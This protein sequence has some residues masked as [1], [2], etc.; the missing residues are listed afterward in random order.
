M[1]VGLGI[2]LA[3]VE[4]IEGA[5]RRFGE[6]FLRRIY[7]E[8]EISYCQSRGNSFERFAGRFAAKEAAMKAIGTG[9]RR[10][11]TWRDFEVTRE[12]SGRPVMR[13][14][15]IAAQVA[16]RLGAK[17]TLLSITHSN[18]LAIAQVILEA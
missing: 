10:G 12:V 3:E 15:G 2:D 6:R 4:R 5:I 16:G 1:I 14:S 7:T 18:A 13:L 9:W 17:R 11:V 8:A